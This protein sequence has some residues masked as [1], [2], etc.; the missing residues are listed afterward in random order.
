MKALI[1]KILAEKTTIIAIFITIASFYLAH[2]FYHVNQ[3]AIF[4]Y[5]HSKFHGKMTHEEIEL[6]SNIGEKPA[7]IVIWILLIPN[8]IWLLLGIKRLIKKLRKE[9]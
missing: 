8:I 4:S 3:V 2:F 1:K 9:K 7:L 6:I 5:F